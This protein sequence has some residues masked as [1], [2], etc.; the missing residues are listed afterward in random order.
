M[1]DLKDLITSLATSDM[2]TAG[3]KVEEFL[4]N[5]L[6]EPGTSLG[7]LLADKINRRRFR[8]LAH[9]VFEAKQLLSGLG[10]TEKEVPLKIIHPLLESASCVGSA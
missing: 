1:S 8:N 4:Q 3:E 9:V 6:K 10:L 7:G 5:V 2:G